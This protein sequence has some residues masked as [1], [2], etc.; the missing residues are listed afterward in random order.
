MSLTRSIAYWH[1]LERRW[2]KSVENMRMHRAS[3]MFF[4]W[5]PFCFFFRQF[6]TL[7]D[8]KIHSI[9]S[10]LFDLNEKIEFL[11]FSIVYMWHESPYHSFRWFQFLKHHLHTADYETIFQKC[12]SKIH[13]SRKCW[14]KQSS[15][16][17]EWRWRQKRNWESPTRQI[18][19]FN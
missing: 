7:S 12:L 6:W 3:I 14:W 19:I 18:C 13:F 17:E 10:L 4:H 2:K 16:K 5:L 11:A 8:Y 1:W 15:D 9:I